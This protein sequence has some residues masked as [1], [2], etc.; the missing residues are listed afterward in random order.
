MYHIP[1]RSPSNYTFFDGL[2]LFTDKR[3]KMS[4]TDG[5]ASNRDD[6]VT[7]LRGRPL[8]KHSIISILSLIMLCSLLYFA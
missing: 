3:K 8:K 4:F 2:L 5:G 1:V 6:M 7:L